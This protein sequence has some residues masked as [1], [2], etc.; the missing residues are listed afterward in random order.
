MK[1]IILALM[2]Y[3]VFCCKSTQKTAQIPD[4]D[5]QE[6]VEEQSTTDT[7]LVASQKTSNEPDTVT[8]NQK[9]S[10]SFRDSIEAGYS[11]EIRESGFVHYIEKNDSVPEILQKVFPDDAIFLK[12][13]HPMGKKNLV[14]VYLEQNQYHLMTNFNI[15]LDKIDLSKEVTIQ[16][17]LVAAVQILVGLDKNVLAENIESIDAK[18]PNT[19]Y[20]INYKIEARVNQN[21]K[22]FYADFENNKLR[23]ITDSLKKPYQ[24]FTPISPI[25]NIK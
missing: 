12:T 19:N 18:L 4:S 8:N 15:L 9:T 20:K 16:D 23:I 25:L 11:V 6:K 5:Q 22:T 13:Y 2:L 14:S 17:K 7:S 24:S 10:L 3:M 21:L 1:Y